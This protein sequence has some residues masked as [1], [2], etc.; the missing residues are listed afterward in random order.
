MKFQVPQFIETETKVVGP[1]TL[2]QFLFVAGGV[3]MS[4]SEF[5]LLPRGIVLYILEFL[6]IVFFGSMAFAKVD[7]QPLLNYAAY[8]LA[9][10]FG[11]KRSVYQ[12]KQDEGPIIPTT[13]GQ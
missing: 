9:Y 5:M 4:A 2:K 10:L 6:T 8:A 13:H 1:F 11:A 3:A 7:G 12:I